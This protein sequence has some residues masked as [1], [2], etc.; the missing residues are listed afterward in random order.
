MASANPT[1]AI[2]F[3]PLLAEAARKDSRA[4]LEQCATPPE[5]WPSPEAEARLAR[6]GPNEV[7]Q[8]KSHGWLG[9]WAR[10]RKSRRHPALGPGGHRVRLGPV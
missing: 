4:V 7:A 10:R 3:S 1:T 9:G 8:E 6:H 5:G 2:R